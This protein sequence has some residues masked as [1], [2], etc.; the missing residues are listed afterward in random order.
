MQKQNSLHDEVVFISFLFIHIDFWIRNF[1]CFGRLCFNGIVILDL[2]DVRLIDHASC[3]VLYWVFLFHVDEEFDGCI[4]SKLILLFNLH[5]LVLIW[6]VTNWP[7]PSL[8][9]NITTIIIIG[10]ISCLDFFSNQNHSHTAW[11]GISEF[12]AHDAPLQLCAHCTFL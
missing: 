9:K 11:L 8:S 2:Q 12:F 3:G 10:S 5:L 7:Y 6:M 4:K 1:L